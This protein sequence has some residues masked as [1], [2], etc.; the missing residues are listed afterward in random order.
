VH[1][2]IDTLGDQRRF[3]LLNEQAFAANLGEQTVLHPVASRMDD[4]GAR[5]IF[6]TPTASISPATA[7]AEFDP[8]RPQR[9]DQQLATR[10][11]KSNLPAERR[12]TRRH[13]VGTPGDMISERPGDIT[14]ISTQVKTQQ[15]PQVLEPAA[16]PGS[17][18]AGGA[19]D[20]RPGGDADEAN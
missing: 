12:S 9:I 18:W 3:Y 4:I 15:R 6:T 2:Q 5:C 1:R 20:R 16:R 7:C 10:Q 19:P 14:G 17:G 13:H 11:K 8:D